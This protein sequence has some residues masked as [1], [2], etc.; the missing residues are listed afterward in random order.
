M[1][2]LGVV[3]AII[4]LLIGFIGTVLFGKIAAIIAIVLGVLA[5]VL[6]ILKRKKEGKGGIA[7]IVIGILAIILAFIMMTSTQTLVKTLKDE[8]IKASGDKYQIA[9]KYAD[10]ADTDSGFYGFVSSLILKAPEEE[11]D[12]LQKELSDVFALLNDSMDGAKDNVEEK[13]DDAKEKVEEKV[14]EAGEKLDEAGEKIDEAI[15]DAGEKIDETI[16]QVIP[17]GENT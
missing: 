8:M 15:D 4:G 6:G 1:G 5:G 7:A 14:D 16:E 10:Q 17:D 12:Q 2:I 13:I 3:L 11:Q 9:R